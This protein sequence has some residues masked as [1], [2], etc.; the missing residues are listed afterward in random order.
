MTR[1]PTFRVIF[2]SRWRL[3]AAVLSVCVA[4]G[5]GVLLAQ[6]PTAQSPT[7]PSQQ[8][9][10]TQGPAKPNAAS[11]AAAQNPQ[12][13]AASNQAE[14]VT[15]DSST[16]FK[17]RVNLVQVRVVVRDE[18]G[19]I[20]ENLKKE[21]FQLLDNRKPQVISTFNVETPNTHALP[22]LS[23]SDRDVSEPGEKVEPLPAMPQRFVSMI[24]DD[25]HLSMQDALTSRVAG[26]KILDSLANTDRVAVYTTSGQITQ[27]FTADHEKLKEALK[28]IIARPLNG[29][30][31]ADCPGISYYQADLIANK[32]DSQA[33]GVAVQDTLQC[34]FGGDQTQI[35]AATS[36]ARARADAVLASGDAASDYA[37]RHIDDVLRRLSAMPGQRKAVFV[38]PGFILSTLLAERSDV[39]D[40]ATK[41]GIVIDTIDARALYTP[42]LLGDIA[43][44]GQQTYLTA[45]FKAS[46]RTDAQFAESEILS[47]FAN[48]TG[49][50]YFHNSNDLE[51][52]LRD[53]IA[54][55]STTYLLGFSP[56]NLKLNGSF[57][58]IKVTL[59]GKRKFT[60]QARRGYYAPRAM[61][62]PE[63]TAKEEIQE[64]VFSQ[65][66]IR[67][68]PL[69]LQTQ[70]FRKDATEVRLSVL[71]H[72]DLRT[73]KFR[74][75]DGRNH[76]DLTLATVIFDENGN[77][78]TGGEKILEMKLLDATLERLDR[79]GITV[80]SSFDVKPGN[81]L[82]RL[83]IRDKE[84]E[85]MA[86]RNGA[87]AIPF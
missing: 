86:A 79:S 71:A 50:S 36:M 51:T 18:R 64:A 10:S 69:D 61:K 26:T 27:E 45:G 48:G 52:G 83:V 72:L 13:G 15:R 35:A 55:P 66:E 77:F 24:F 47:D 32:S 41:A 65:E 22:V 54:A 78:V 30:T 17:V 63:E 81:Y 23:V 43:N 80:K 3:P 5:F 2:R 28:Q 56:Q 68:L 85:S 60:L 76:D 4:A 11:A 34:A 49:G 57:H 20:V 39:I 67:D 19:K 44:P 73:L 70:F 6:Q 33:L 75:V 16:S 7:Q 37:Y 87:V 62:D 9:P 53:S 74:K 46:Y 31:I 84:G 40:R 82:V 38:S 8:S 58:T 21:D 14:V 25:I 42:D 29:S 59:T 1:Q 12:T